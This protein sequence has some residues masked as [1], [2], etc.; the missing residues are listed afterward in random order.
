[1]AANWENGVWALGLGINVGSKIIP[2]LCVE[3]TTTLRKP[4]WN[5]HHYS[6]VWFWKGKKKHK[7]QDMQRI[8]ILLEAL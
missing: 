7:T 8:R 2:G 4:V 6:R 3:E 1:M 5:H